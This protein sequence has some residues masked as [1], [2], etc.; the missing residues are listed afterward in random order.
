MYMYRRNSP[1]SFQSEWS[2]KMVSRETDKKLAELFKIFFEC[3]VDR[4]T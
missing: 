2:Y 4:A 1:F 3:F